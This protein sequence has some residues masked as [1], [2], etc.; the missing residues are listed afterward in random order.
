MRKRLSARAVLAG[1]TV[2]AGMALASVSPANA[3]S[4]SQSFTVP[5]GKLFVSAYECNVFM[6]SC[7]WYTKVQLQNSTKVMDSIT[8]TTNIYVNGISASVTI[9]KDQ[10]SATITANQTKT[11][12]VKW[13]KYVSN[14]VELSG[15]ARPTWT[16]VG[17]TT[18]ACLTGNGPGSYGTVSSKC[19]RIGLW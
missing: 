8:N 3:A 7:S 14:L 19:T 5:Y 10:P 6:T 11:A 9:S 12:T 18:E 13:T 2:A 16:A 1:I 4:S 15:E 17:I